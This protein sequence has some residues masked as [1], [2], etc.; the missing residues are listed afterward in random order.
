MK[1][2]KTGGRKKGTPNKIPGMAS[3]RSELTRFV[4][5][6]GVPAM[7]KKF[8]RLTATNQLFF[9]TR[10][11]PFVTAQYSNVSM[12]LQDMS[13]EDLELILAKVTERKNNEPDD[14]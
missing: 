4:Q 8:N 1:G 9:L 3:I 14:E 13:E 11:L 6:K 10:L 2:K 5:E 12:R 7:F